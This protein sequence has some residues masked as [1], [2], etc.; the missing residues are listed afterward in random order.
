[1][2]KK[3]PETPNK[4]PLVSVIIP[5]FNHG[6]YIGQAIESV[7]S[8]SFTDYEII[9]VDD[10]SSDGTEQVLVPYLDRISV[11]HQPNQGPSRA[12]NK[13][14]EMARGQ[15]VAFLDADDFFLPDKLAS[16]IAIANQYPSIGVV[17]GGWTMVDQRGEFLKKVEPWL[18]APHLDL[19]AWL[20]W[21]PVCLGASLIRRD[22][23]ER[24]N[25]FDP[26]LRLAQD[27]DLMLR[28]ALHGC[29][30]AWVRRPVVCY[31]QHDANNML[32][33]S[34]HVKYVWQVLDKFFAQPDIPKRVRRMENEVRYSTALWFAWRLY[35]AGCPKEC[36]DFLG[37]AVSFREGPAGMDMLMEWAWK[38]AGWFQE[39]GGELSD[40]S[41]M[42]SYVRGIARVDNR[43]WPDDE[44]AL[45][46]WNQ[47]WWN[48]LDR[49]EALVSN[50][51]EIYR[52]LLP[53]EIISLE[54]SHLLSVPKGMMVS[55][56]DRFWAEVLKQCL[57]PRKNRHD[58]VSLYLTILG[59]AVMARRWDVAWQSLGRSLRHSIS[60]GAIIAWLS[61]LK[62]GMVYTLGISQQNGSAN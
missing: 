39:H 56:V 46:W 24:M 55:R 29:K 41:G 62:T 43:I 1:M 22:W 10:G 59:Q 16:Q 26:V 40:Y 33:V 61:F 17:H 19:N 50:A 28:L 34:L 6:R 49:K 31:R 25:G 23:L 11:F 52:G 15:Y 45:A 13:G 20:W 27:T 30:M 7:F 47:I 14:V 12:R 37:R 8:Q 3:A 38:F 2:M 18:N 21:R 60:P 57:V 9:V 53:A 35:R 44:K 54:K 5:S 36:I 58:V 4:G 32:N 42:L 51:L 48:S